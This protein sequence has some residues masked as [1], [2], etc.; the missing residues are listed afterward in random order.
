MDFTIKIIYYKNFKKNYR[1]L[2]FKKYTNNHF[3]LVKIQYIRLNKLQY[4]N[5]FKIHVKYI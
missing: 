4:Q 2:I 3:F 5:I 1:V